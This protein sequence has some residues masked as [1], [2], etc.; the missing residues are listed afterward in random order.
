VGADGRGYGF[1]QR[2]ANR[3]SVAMDE[4]TYRA[5]KEAKLCPSKRNALSGGAERG[6]GRGLLGCNTWGVTLGRQD[7]KKGLRVSLDWAFRNYT[8]PKH[9]KLSPWWQNAT[10][11]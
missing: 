2:G 9:E 11:S 5:W 4:S 3:G 7:E 6:N 10:G 8:N 1:I